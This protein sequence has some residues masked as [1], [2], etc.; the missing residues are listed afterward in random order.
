MESLGIIKV[1]SVHWYVRDMARTRRFYTELMDFEE[2]GESS[3]ELTARGRQQSVVF[4]ANDVQLICSAPVGQ[5]GRA[6]RWLE[7]HPEGVGTVNF[8]V[9]DVEKTWKLLESRGGTIIDDGLQRF[10]DDKGGRLA[11]FSITTPFGNTTFRFIQRDGYEALY[12]G[13]QRHAAPRGGK[14]RFGFGKIDHITSNFRTLQPMVLWM[15]HVMGFEEF[16]NIQFHTEEEIEKGNQHGTGLKSQVMWDPHSTVKFANNE[17]SR[18][19]FKQSQIN[20]F[21]EDQ[22]GEG[23]QHLALLV[24]DIVPA[25]REMRKTNGLDFLGTPAAYYDYLPE[26]IQ[27]SGIARI[28][29]RLDELRE[30]QILIDG[31]KEHQYLLQ[32][33]MKENGHLMKD[34]E[35]GP[36]FYEIIERKGDKGFGGG[37]FKALFESIERAQ[38]AARAG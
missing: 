13:F 28:D 11:F 14:N 26:R 5:G 35:A 18:P 17:P 1:E 33:F 3:P 15:K 21:V 12:P 30:L 20:V 31:H 32:I 19:R 8:L 25:V 9:K 27:K 34:R 38:T 36:F 2:L 10:S 4:K 22:R 7:K 29:E 24:K 23:I 37:N 16:W 6:W